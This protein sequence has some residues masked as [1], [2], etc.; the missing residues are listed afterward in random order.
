VGS[1]TP[2]RT[3][4]AVT[5]TDAWDPNQYH[6]L[7]G[8]RSQPFFDLLAL[9]E[10]DDTA[11]RV[12]D[13][14]CGTGELTAEA[15]AAL[16]A[17]QTIGIDSSASM[18]EQAAGLHMAGLS[19]REGDLAQFGDPDGVDVIVS[20]AALHWVPDHDAVLARWRDALRAG[21]QIAV[22]MPTNAD[23]PSHVLARAVA[24]E[25]PFLSAFDGEPPTDPVLR[26]RSPE[27]YAVVLDR[28]GFPRQHV[29]VQVYP[30]RMAS[31][32][33][34]V[35]WVKGTNLTRFEARLPAGLYAEY[36]DRYRTRLLDTL[37]DQRPYLYTFKR[38]LFWARL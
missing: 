15:H 36:L 27:D 34:V 8:E 31:T 38:V 5:A 29:R 11:P 30:H 28:L 35:E 22:Q 14:G 18:L 12:V 1:T 33:E 13:L 26:V 37:G 16:G 21:G 19:F 2:S 20:N 7:R 25:E 6:R 24:E 3:I 23:H 17:T 10:R 4:L 32:S 9:V